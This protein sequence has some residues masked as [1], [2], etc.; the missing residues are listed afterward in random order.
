[1]TTQA[2]IDADTHVTEPPDLWT[3][4]LSKKWGDLIPEV[5][6]D[7]D[8]GVEC[9]FA[10]DRTY[11]P[12]A[13]TSSVNID[14]ETGEPAEIL[15]E[16]LFPRRFEEVHPSSYDP[17]ARLEVMDARGI[18]AHVL[19]PNM[20]FVIGDFQSVSKDRSYQYEILRAYNDWLV[21]FSAADPD[22]LIPLALVPFYDAE[23]AAK[24][25]LR[26]K[27]LG[28]RGVVMTG[29]PQIHDQPFL[30][31]PQWNPLWSA[32]QET[33]MSINFHLGAGPQGV[34]GLMTPERLEHEGGAKGIAP[35][36]IVETFIGNC[37]SMTDIIMSGVLARYPELK[38]VSVEGGIG[39]APFM[40]DALDYHFV[41]Y[42][43]GR[44]RPEFEELPSFYFERQCFLTYWF[45]KAD[46]FYV[47]RLGADHI[48]FETDYPH[49]VSLTPPQVA[50]AIADGMA[51]LSNADKQQILWKNAS[52]L[53]GIAP[54]PGASTS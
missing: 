38:V 21:E 49:S 12:I 13:N 54:P 33:G 47:E 40:L 23:L 17:D 15:A 51:G 6:I 11:G 37:N 39:W 26:A 30:S 43:S 27:E 3:S 42:D 24:E 19:Y 35:R 25:V 50:D 44:D 32:A 46:P 10:G 1:M 7:D 36:N 34:A 31:D 41:R 45:E 22:R 29:Q 8:L 2:I 48:L 53:Y 18:W 28:H 14:P 9:W 16:L 52:A 5:R 20:N 4:R